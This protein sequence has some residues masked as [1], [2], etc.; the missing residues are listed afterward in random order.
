LKVT[1]LRPGSLVTLG[2]DSGS[3]SVETGAAL[4]SI[5]VNPELPTVELEEDRV[6]G[7]V[8]PTSAVLH[9]VVAGTAAEPAA[10]TGT[11]VPEETDGVSPASDA[12]T[13]AV[14]GGNAWETLGSTEEPT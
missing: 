11:G 14:S 4:V 7:T 1:A 3:T 13:D 10:V 12:D 5:V 8:T 9:V 6:T 2:L